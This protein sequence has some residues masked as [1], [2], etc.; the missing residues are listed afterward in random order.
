MK[1]HRTAEERAWWIRAGKHTPGP[2]KAEN[3]GDHWDITTKHFFIAKTD[4]ANAQLIAS[5]PDLL[6][7]CNTV[8][9]YF[10]IRRLGSVADQMVVILS[11]AIAKA[12]K[13]GE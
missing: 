7:A 1:D 10:K 9:K 5:A 13:G 4:K 3:D 2:W 11:K 8:R 6:E 12:T